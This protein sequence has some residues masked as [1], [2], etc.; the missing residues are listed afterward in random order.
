MTYEEFVELLRQEPLHFTI[1]ALEET[2]E[3]SQSR[4]F[5]DCYGY[6]SDVG[7]VSTDQYANHRQEP[8]IVKPAYTLRWCSGGSTG[9]SCYGTKSDQPV[10]SEPEPSWTD[11]DATFAV[12]C[13]NISYL[14]YKH[15]IDMAEHRQHHD[16]GD[17]YG[18]YYSYHVKVLPV[19]KLWEYLIQNKLLPEN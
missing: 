12:F 4:P 11:L 10:S 6:N 3:N 18:N 19:Y 14:H 1:P 16:G 8:T 7:M 15:I 9:G 17:Y 13:P 2:V 5:R